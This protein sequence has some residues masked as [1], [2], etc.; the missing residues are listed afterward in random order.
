MVFEF[1]P[2]EWEF[3]AL[4]FRIRAIEL[5]AGIT[6]AVATEDDCHAAPGV[7]G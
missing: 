2:G 5:E 4:Q 6:L 7:D 3:I 1:G